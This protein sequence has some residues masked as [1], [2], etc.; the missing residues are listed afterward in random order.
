MTDGAAMISR[1]LQRDYPVLKNAHDHLTSR[2][3]DQFWTSGQWM[4]E[5]E[6]GSEAGFRPH[7]HNPRIGPPSQGF[8]ARIPGFPTPKIVS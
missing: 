7:R 2:D 6:G 3:P 5:K 4:T 1:D 8:L